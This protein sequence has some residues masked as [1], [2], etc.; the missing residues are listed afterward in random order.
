[1]RKLD[2]K[3]VTS[4]ISRAILGTNVVTLTEPSIIVAD[5]LTPSQTVAFDRKLILGFVLRKGTM[6]S[7]ASILARTMN[8][9]SLIN[10]DCQMS[11]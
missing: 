4:R 9:P 6:N 11:H 2:V 8:I 5:D 1:M 7:H 10:T 3:D